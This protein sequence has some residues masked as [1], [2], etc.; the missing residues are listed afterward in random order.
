MR[1]NAEISRARLVEAATEEFAARGYDGAR[2]DGI[3]ARAEVSKNLVYHYFAG[4]EALFIAVMERVYVLMRAHHQDDLLKQLE[5]RAA[6]E[7]LIRSVHRLF[8]ERPEIITLLNSE[9]LHKAAHIAKSGTIR[10]LYNPLLEALIDI[11]DRGSAAGVFRRGVDPVDLYITISGLSYVL[12]LQ[13]PH[14]DLHL[15]RG[16]ARRGAARPARA[17]HR[18]GGAGLSRGGP[19]EGRGQPASGARG[20]ARLTSSRP[21]MTRTK[22][23][24]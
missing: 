9:N 10:T 11:L 24:A 16:P 1:R 17:A 21:A 19:G 15:Q 20:V 22:P 2:V 18:R 5:P 6:I 8:V 23:S 13:R 4:K 12:H 7:R 3:V 14:P